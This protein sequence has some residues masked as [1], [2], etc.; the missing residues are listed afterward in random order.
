MLAMT[1][2]YRSTP[3]K[4]LEVILGWHP[5]HSLVKWQ[6]LR[7]SLRIKDTFYAK[8]DGIGRGKMSLYESF[9]LC[10]LLSVFTFGDK[11]LLSNIIL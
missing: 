7:V 10:L 1:F 11:S 6:G 4:G 3:S 2:V 8:W 9:G 5:L